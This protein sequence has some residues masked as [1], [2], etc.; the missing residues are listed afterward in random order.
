VLFNTYPWAFAT[1]GGGEIQLLK[2]AEHLPAHGVEVAW[3]DTWNPE[4]DAVDAVHF[5]SSIGG[6]IAFCNY[7][8]N[9]GL[10]LVVSSSLWITRATIGDFPTGE[11]RAQLALADVIVPNSAS[12]A[13]MLARLLELP[14]ELFMPVMNGVDTRFA[15]PPDPGLF[16]GRFGIEGPFVLT[17]GNIETRKNQLNLVRALSAHGPPL[18]MVG[19]VREPGYAEHVFAEAGSRT[20]SLGPIAHDDPLLASAYGACSVFVLPS[21]LE[22]PGLAALEAAAAGAPLVIT[23]EGS[24]REYFRDM[25]HYVDPAEPD[26]IRRKIEIALAAGPDP[27]LRTL[28]T[29]RFTWPTVTAA[30]AEVYTAA[31]SRNRAGAR[32]T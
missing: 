17:V 15:H 30:L 29:T 6:S 13:D 20:R 24:T 16:R 32:R 25:V 10:P 11:I 8:K 27:R 28:I 22:T 23:S 2:Y 18:V 1:P 9:R 19:D 12:E 3:H 14:R 7:V 4:F 26:D 31:V 21:T 5:F